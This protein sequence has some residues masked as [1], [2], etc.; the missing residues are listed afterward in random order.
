M[1]E[2]AKAP[3]SLRAEARREFRNWRSGWNLDPKLRMGLVRRQMLFLGEHPVRLCLSVVS[4]YAAWVICLWLWTCEPHRF[5]SP[6]L[7][8]PLG[9]IAELH[10]SLWAVQATLA[11]LLY[12]IVLSFATLFMSRRGGGETIVHLY[13]FD[14]AALV[15]GLSAVLLVLVMSVQYLVYSL[16]YPQ[17]AHI[18]TVLNA[19]WFLLNAVAT[20]FFLFRTVEFLRRDRQLTVKLRYALSVALPRQVETLL[21]AKVINDAARN[22]RLLAHE[23]LVEDGPSVL[24]M[25]LGSRENESAYCLRR[26]RGEVRLHDVRMRLLQKAILRWVADAKGTP[27]PTSTG[28]QR[29]FDWPCLTIN[30]VPGHKYRG[31]TPLISVR[32]GPAP[33][34][35]TRTLFQLAFS[36]RS[37]NFEKAH[38]SVADLLEEQAEEARLALAAVDHLAFERAYDELTD[39]ILSML[40]LCEEGRG[41]RGGSYASLP[42]PENIFARSLFAGWIE[43]FRPLVRQSLDSMD[44]EQKSIRAL[45]AFPIRFS[46][47]ALRGAAPNLRSEALL[48]PQ[49]L[50]YQL[51]LWWLDQATATQ[52]GGDGSGCGRV[53]EGPLGRRYETA[54]GLAVTAWEHS[55]DVL[56]GGLRSKKGSSWEGMQHMAALH[57]EHLHETVVRLLAAVARRDEV[58]A[59]WL[60]DVLLKWG[61]EFAFE[62]Q[63]WELYRCAHTIDVA[64]LSDAWPAVLGS[65]DFG[66]LRV[67]DDPAGDEHLQRGVFLAAL[68]NLWDDVRLLTLEV[69]ISWALDPRENAQLRYYSRWCAAKLLKGAELRMG[70]RTESPLSQFTGTDYL[71][72]VLRRE[73]GRFYRHQLHEL[74]RRVADVRRPEMISSRTY[75]FNGMLQA[76]LK[77]ARPI[78]LVAFA[79]APFSGARGGAPWTTWLAPGSSEARLAMETLEKWSVDQAQLNDDSNGLAEYLL[80]QADMPVN[81][82]ERGARAAKG[83]EGIVSTLSQAHVE[84]ILAAKISAERIQELAS[85]AS[86]SAFSH[87]HGRFPLH[88]FRTVSTVDAALSKHELP[89]M[90]VRKSELIFEALEPRAY[91][92]AE[93]LSD[94]MAKVVASVVLDDVRTSSIVQTLE[95]ETE[96]LYWEAF[97]EAVKS[98]QERGLEP[99]LVLD[100]R[101]SPGWIQNMPLDTDDELQSESPVQVARRKDQS[102]GYLFHVDD[103]AAYV[104]A[105]PAGQSWVMP[106]EAFDGVEFRTTEG[107]YVDIEPLPRSDEPLTYDL[108]L[109]FE[110][111]VKSDGLPMYVLQFRRTPGNP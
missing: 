97:K 106:K 60:I 37:T 42:D 19:A 50:F 2:Q 99:L 20:V 95:C 32:N 72:S 80:M 40:E 92:E 5:G 49:L 63:P 1:E 10:A 47:D 24:F 29:K 48:V 82:A 109:G 54:M 8:D 55:R 15:T 4:L 3:R 14:S 34:L 35:I 102:K 74:L 28:V 12:P 52:P 53:V 94:F 83:I 81:L 66:G 16:G 104:G 71:E 96:S 98:L 70:G 87:V 73:V 100:G 91:N 84:A 6:A 22:K 79:G 61:E 38:V 68:R 65:L 46:G 107:R 56:I 30:A 27:P 103:V 59:E 41:T 45:A 67:A 26:H 88:Q 39:L 7:L 51:G 105:I 110:R 85:F 75:S 62:H 90:R 18:M 23:T 93:A 17:V 86:K 31:P 64:R 13:V 33:D 78:A 77:G 101:M 108:L 58:G 9:D 44:S 25:S 89:P 57:Q 21:G 69:L 36:F 11:G 76:E 111:Q 43:S